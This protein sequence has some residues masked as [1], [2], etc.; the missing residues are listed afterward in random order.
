[1]STLSIINQVSNFVFRSEIYYLTFV[2]ISHFVA[3]A[4]VSVPI[5]DPS[6]LVS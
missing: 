2:D 1:M 3:V 4:V 5:D 6:V